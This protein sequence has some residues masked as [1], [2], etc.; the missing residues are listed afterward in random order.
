NHHGLCWEDGDT[1]Y[2]QAKTIIRRAVRDNLDELCET[3]E[4]PNARIYVKGLEKKKWLQEILG[5]VDATI[6]TVDAEY[7]DIDR[8]ESLRTDRAFRCRRHQRCCAMEN[9]MKLRD[10]WIEQRECFASIDSAN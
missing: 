7:E 6:V 1:D 4:T 5:D 9:V 10:W 8:L 3:E 2:R